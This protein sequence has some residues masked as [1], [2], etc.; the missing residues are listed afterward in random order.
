M[1]LLTLPELPYAY[2]ALEPWMSSQVLTL[3]HDKHHQAYVDGANKVQAKLAEARANGTEVDYKALMKEFSFHLGGHVLHKLFWKTLRGATE[4][5]RPN[6]VLLEAINQA[7]GTFERFQ[8]EF[9]KTANSVEGS[10]WAIL[11]ACPNSRCLLLS[12]VEKHNVN[13]LMNFQPILV[14]DVWEHSYY[15]DYQNNRAKF[16][17]GFWN[18]VNWDEVS[19]LY[20]QQEKKCQC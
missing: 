12:Q 14:L 13:S 19:K 15:L 18:H 11:N 17:E 5:N 20:E 6:G 16:V 3:H 8:E 1:K 2:D 7:F 4:N 9:S 10:G